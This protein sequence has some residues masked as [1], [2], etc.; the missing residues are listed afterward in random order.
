MEVLTVWPVPGEA[1]QLARKTTWD[2]P[3]A[4]DDPGA[5]GLLLADIA[6]YAAK[7]YASEGRSETEVFDRIRRF[8]EA[9]FASPTDHSIRL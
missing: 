2:H 7:A 5:W 6:R 4:W 1:Q 8:F 3:G 9:E